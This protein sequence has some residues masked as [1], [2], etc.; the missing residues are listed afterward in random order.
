ML[1][2]NR[3]C[4]F[5]SRHILDVSMAISTQMVFS[6]GEYGCITNKEIYTRSLAPAGFSV[7]SAHFQKIAYAF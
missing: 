1:M 2:H 7:S 4:T 5:A 3:I 6:L